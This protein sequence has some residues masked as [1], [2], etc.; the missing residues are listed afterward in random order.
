MRGD[1]LMITPV[2]DFRFGGRKI[3]YTEF[4]MAREH[5]EV[6]YW[7]SSIILGCWVVVVLVLVVLVVLVLAV[8]VVVVVVV[9]EVWVARNWIRESSVE[10]LADTLHSRTLGTFW[11]MEVSGV[12][13]NTNSSKNS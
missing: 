10:S 11:R 13:S 2:S 7:G 12:K 8:V 5:S 1:D 3:W 4:A 9:G 6:K